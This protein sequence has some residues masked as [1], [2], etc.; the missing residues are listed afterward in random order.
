[1]TVGA[2][3]GFFLGALAWLDSGML[4]A[5][6]IVLVLLGVVSGFWMAR[7]MTRIGPVQARW[8]VP[9]GRPW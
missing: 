1:V 6:V 4:I 7:R 3:V 2:F 8:M 9:S 5:G